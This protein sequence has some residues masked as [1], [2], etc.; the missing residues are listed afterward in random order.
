MLRQASDILLKLYRFF[1]KYDCTILEINP[2]AI[3]K[4]NKVI[5]AASVMAVDDSAMF[6]HP[7]LADM[8]QVGSDRAWRPLSDL[9]K[10]VVE[11]NE[12]DPYRGTARYTEMDG[13]DIGF[14]CGGGGASLMMFDALLS[15]GGKPANYTEFGGNPPEKKVYGLVIGILSK[16]GVRGLIVCGNITNNTQVDVV[17]R[18]I[19]AAI[20]DK[21]IDPRTFPVLVRYAGVND[22]VGREV[23][24]AAGIEY[25]GEEIT[26][27]VAAKKMVEKMSQAYRGAEPQVTA[28][29][30]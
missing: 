29:G 30:A 11:V 27:T 4:D 15:Y 17:S 28:H 2:L 24:T 12:S 25:Y 8:V 6:R 13:G 21:G 3:T 10:Q 20:K 5:A 22:A 26:M 14:M 7:E 19:V 23:F 9:E 16:P 18:G 1:V